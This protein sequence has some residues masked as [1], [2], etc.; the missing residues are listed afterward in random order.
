[1]SHG[2]R[3]GD[4]WEKAPCESLQ[5]SVGGLRSQYKRLAQSP[6]L[7]GTERSPHFE[8][9][10][11]SFGLSLYE[12]TESLNWIP[13]SNFLAR[14]SRLLKMIMN[15]ISARI[16]ELHISLQS[17]NESNYGRVGRN[18]L[19]RDGWSRLTSLFT[20]VSVIVI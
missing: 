18:Q 10:C 19:P 20:E 3:E 4:G 9:F 11:A 16:F 12:V 8:T 7:N 14:R 17:W 1:M 6:L 2:R 5:T 15:V 13:A